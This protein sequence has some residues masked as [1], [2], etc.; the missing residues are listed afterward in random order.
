MGTIDEKD[1]GV[2]KIKE[3]IL[4]YANEEGRGD[5]LWPFRFALSGKE[6]SI[7]PFTLSYILGKKET[8][9]RIEN[10]IQKLG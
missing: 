6:K 5:V 10:A 7:D 8:I 2:E 9:K 4:P 1:F 3:I